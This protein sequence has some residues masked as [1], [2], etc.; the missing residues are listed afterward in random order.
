MKLEWGAKQS[1]NFGYYHF[2]MS[3][4]GLW[5]AV[6]TWRRAV[7]LCPDWHP[8]V[9]SMGALYS[10]AQPV[11]LPQGLLMFV[12]MPKHLPKSDSGNYYLQQK[13]A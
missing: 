2:R 4:P 1:R 10:T 6:E 12:S 13:D 7:Q 8:P 9:G 5:T 3:C 11:Q